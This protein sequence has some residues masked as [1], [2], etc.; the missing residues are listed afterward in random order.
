MVAG[1]CIMLYILREC[2]RFFFVFQIRNIKDIIRKSNSES[3]RIQS[4]IE[5][6]S[7]E[8]EP[9]D[10]CSSKGKKICI[11]IAQ[12]FKNCPKGIGQKSPIRG[13]DS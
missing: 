6:G 3:S 11:S 12:Y 5:D 4:K 10:Q 8:K 13:Y 1:L 9:N 2:F 7:E